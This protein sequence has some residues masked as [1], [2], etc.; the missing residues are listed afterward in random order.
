MTVPA[1]YPKRW[2]PHVC[3]SSRIHRGSRYVTFPVL[4]QIFHEDEFFSPWQRLVGRY[5][6]PKGCFVMALKFK[7]LVYLKLESFYMSVYFYT[8]PNYLSTCTRFIFFSRITISF[9]FIDCRS[10]G[11]TVE[12]DEN[13][14]KWQLFYICFAFFMT[15]FS[16]QLVVLV[17]VLPYAHAIQLREL[18]TESDCDSYDRV[19]DWLH[20]FRT[21]KIV[22][23][24]T[25]WIHAVVTIECIWHLRRKVWIPRLV[26]KIRCDIVRSIYRKSVSF[27]EDEEDSTF[28]SVVQWVW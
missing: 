9:K 7:S 4:T 26:N 17:A 23:R 15:F 25:L 12:N 22:Y 14:F 18:A 21:T 24:S 6:F 10:K 5:E 19:G 27:G 3:G 1:I 8:L 13:W 11:S 2:D 28:P 16:Y 20:T